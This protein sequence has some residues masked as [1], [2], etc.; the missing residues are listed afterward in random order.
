MSLIFNDNNLRC[1]ECSCLTFTQQE[2]FGLEK[3]V[4]KDNHVY[5]KKIQPKYILK[6]TNCNNVISSTDTS[7]LLPIANS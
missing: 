2:V 5:Y 6:C 3:H 1:Q 7:I 4:S